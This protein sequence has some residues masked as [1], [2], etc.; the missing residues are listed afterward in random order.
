MYGDIVKRLESFGYAVATADEWALRYLIEKVTNTVKNECNVSEIPDGLHQVA[1]DMACG[2]F[3]MAKKGTGQLAGFD[4]D[5]AVKQIH[6]GDTSVTFAFGEGS[7]TPEQRLDN[8]ITRLMSYGK[9]QFAAY[10]R[11]RW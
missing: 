8:L 4:L 7:T 6:E 10:R 11:L 1:V 5:A 3:L 9:P 2:E